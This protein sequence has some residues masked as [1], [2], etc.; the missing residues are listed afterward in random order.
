MMIST[1]LRLSV[2]THTEPE[3]TSA[4]LTLIADYSHCAH[5]PP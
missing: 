5:L 1:F 4:A 3:Y 2:Q